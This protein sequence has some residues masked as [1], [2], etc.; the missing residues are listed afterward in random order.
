MR[1]SDCVETRPVSKAHTHLCLSVWLTR[2]PL[3][4]PA[5]QTTEGGAI[6]PKGSGE[7]EK[8]AEE[9]PELVSP[10]KSKL[11]VKTT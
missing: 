1:P 2:R 4:C 6:P 3:Q 10:I 11:P 8:R 5:E 7:C 9:P